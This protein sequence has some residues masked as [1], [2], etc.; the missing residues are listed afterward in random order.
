MLSSGG[1]ENVGGVD[2]VVARTTSEIMLGS[3][4]HASPRRIVPATKFIP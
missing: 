2:E 4:M 3:S 1:V